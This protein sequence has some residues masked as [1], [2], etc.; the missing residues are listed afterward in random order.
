MLIKKASN[1]IAIRASPKP[2]ADLMIDARRT[3]SIIKIKS[4]CLKINL[5][6]GKYILTK[7]ASE[8]H[9]GSQ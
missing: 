3:I 1:G 2:K 9:R 7:K 4:K 8:F 5:L 6:E